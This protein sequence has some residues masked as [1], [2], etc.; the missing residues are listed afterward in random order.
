MKGVS[1]SSE[2]PPES[3]SDDGLTVNIAGMKWYPKED[4]LSLNIGEVV[5]SKKTRGRK[6]FNEEARKI[7][8]KLTRRHC[9]SKVAE[10]FDLT[11]KM[12]PLVSSFQMDLHDLVRRKLDWDDI[13]PDELRSKWILNLKIIGE[14]GKINLNVQLFHQMQKIWTSTQLIL[15]T[16]LK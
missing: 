11:G 12:M 13:I 10:V 14:I 16:P 4:M 15:V 3:M 1:L 5:F 7:P 8:A 6:I 2:D 9:V